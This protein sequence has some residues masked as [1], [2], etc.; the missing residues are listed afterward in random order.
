[1]RNSRA[2]SLLAAEIQLIAL[3]VRAPVPLSTGEWRV[4]RTL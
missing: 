2:A 1:M 3:D 4:E